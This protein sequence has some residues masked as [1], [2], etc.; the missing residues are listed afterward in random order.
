[1]NAD[2]AR[3]L[4]ANATAGPWKYRPREFDDWGM[5]RDGNGEHLVALARAGR[6]VDDAEFDQHRTNNTDPYEGNARLIESARSL[7]ETVIA[8]D[9]EI[10]RLRQEVATMRGLERGLYSELVDIRNDVRRMCNA[11]P[12]G[13]CPPSL[14]CPP[15]LLTAYQ[16]LAQ[17]VEA[18]RVA[19]SSASRHLQSGDAAPAPLPPFIE[20]IRHRLS[21]VAHIPIS[22]ENALSGKY[23]GTEIN[24]GSSE[25]K[26]WH[27][28]RS[29][30]DKLLPSKNELEQGYGDKDTITV[31]EFF[32]EF[33]P[34]SS[35]WQSEGDDHMAEFLLH[36]RGDIAALLEFCGI[37]APTIKEQEV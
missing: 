18:A 14:L 30:V 8:Q 6:D 25:V 13:D 21:R 36:A 17:A 35:H 11:Y 23:Y 27:C 15:A 3:F 16:A 32:G 29:D 4:L 10:E 20:A 28:D 22:G 12:E 9:A 26:L 5:V 19:Y 33:S 2:E 34:C 37:E 24:I 31:E 1:M 7:A